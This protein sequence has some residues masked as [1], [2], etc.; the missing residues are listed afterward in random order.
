MYLYINMEVIILQRIFKYTDLDKIKPLFNDIRFYMGKS[1]LDG[2]MGEAY[3]DN[4]LSPNIAFLV[5]R[6]YCFI[7]GN[8][9]KEKL[10]YIIDENFK[11]HTLIPSDNLKKEIENIYQSNI[12]KSQRYSIKKEVIFDK[13]NLTNMI[14]NLPQNFKLFKITKDLA[15]RI[16][17]EK[18]ICI[19]DDYENNGIG[20]CC[21]Y[22]N[23]IIGVASSNIFYKDGIEVNIRV[24]DNY[25][26]K[27]IASAMASSLILECLK[28]HKKISWDAYNMNS[29]FLAKKLGFEFD[30]AYDVYELKN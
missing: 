22:N 29:V 13:A 1:V 4:I 20:Y 10:K 27:G 21:M 24:K 18:F 6:S 16:K 5:V 26:R 15:D 3:V 8:L 7:S 12:I 19:T 30:S 9:N 2:V 17:R 11:N 14:N 25:R 23:K 28:E